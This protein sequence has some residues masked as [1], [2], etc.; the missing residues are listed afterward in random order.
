MAAAGLL[1]KHFAFD[2]LSLPF[3][4]GPSEF[5]QGR[6]VTYACTC[7]LSYRTMQRPSKKQKSPWFPTSRIVSL[8]PT[9]RM[10]EI[11]QSAG[12]QLIVPKWH[13]YMKVYFEPLRDASGLGPTLMEMY[14]LTSIS[15]LPLV[16]NGRLVCITP[17]GSGMPQRTFVYGLNC[18]ISNLTEGDRSRLVSFCED[19]RSKFMAGSF[20]FKDLPSTSNNGSVFTIFTKIRLHNKVP[21]GAAQ[22]TRGEPAPTVERIESILDS[23]GET[24]TWTDLL[25]FEEQNANNVEVAQF[26]KKNKDDFAYSLLRRHKINF[27]GLPPRGARY[28]WTAFFEGALKPFVCTVEIGGKRAFPALIGKYY[29]YPQLFRYMPIP[30]IENHIIGDGRVKSKVAKV[31][32]RTCV[33]SMPYTNVWP[34]TFRNGDRAYQ[35]VIRYLGD[36]ALAALLITYARAG[37]NVT[38]VALPGVSLDVAETAKLYISLDQYFRMFDL[39]SEGRYGWLTQEGT[40][41]SG[42]RDVLSLR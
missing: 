38:T 15:G 34:H 30:M 31:T 4:I 42:R 17:Y 21:R 28:N 14:D 2:A 12:D 33:V 22:T 16:D 26:F 11:L 20:S 18:D 41:I 23:L 10:M 3:S 1:Q 5:L 19:N 6:L 37:R 24:C 8:D 7:T 13:Q 32:Y 36:P 27:P 25:N 35:G 29:R 40:L 39:M 9:A